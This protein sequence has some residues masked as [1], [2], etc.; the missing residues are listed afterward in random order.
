[1]AIADTISSMYD[2]V[3]DI[4]DTLELGGD[5]TQNKNIVNINTEIKR[6]YKDFLA[7]GTDTLWNN[8]EKVEGEGETLSLNNTMEGK[9]KVDLKGNTYQESTTGKNLFDIGT[10]AN[11]YT[12][13]NYISSI[14][15]NSITMVGAGGLSSRGIRLQN[16]ATNKTYTIGFDT[17][18]TTNR[19]L[20]RIR[21]S[22]DTGWLTN[23]DITFDGWNY[24]GTYGAWYKDFTKSGNRAT[25]TTTIP[26]GLYWQFGIVNAYN[27]TETFSNIQIEL[28]NQ[29]TN[30]EPYTGGQPSPSPSYP[31]DIQVVSGDNSINVSGENKFDKDNPNVIEGYIAKSNATIYLSNNQIIIYVPCQ[32]NTTYYVKR[33]LVSTPTNNVFRIGTTSTIPTSGSVLSQF[34][35]PDNEETATDYTFTTNANA[36]YIV[37]YCYVR[38][39]L[40]LIK[41]G[42]YIGECTTSPIS[43][44]NIEL[45]KIGTYQ[46]SIVKDNGKWYLNKQIGKAVLDGS[47]NWDIFFNTNG[48]FYYYNSIS[49]LANQ[50]SVNCLSNYFKATYRAYIR[51]NLDDANNV[52]A[53]N[54]TE[55]VI[56]N[57]N[58]SSASDFKTWLSTH[59]T[60]LYYVLAT[61]TYEEITGELLSQLE[62]LA[63]SYEG[64][65]NISQVND[66]M[67]FVLD[68]TALKDM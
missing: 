40:D 68:I 63:Y 3:G 65:T 4:Y 61:P 20:I 62:A 59:N 14:S 22:S 41:N 27:E 56:A 52:C 8:W 34:Y 19:G 24:N 49:G 26:N 67:P 30:W 57:K 39:S 5:T 6:E 28:N 17:N 55:F 64:T 2:H 43:L 32:P 7:N 45:C 53:V 18:V 48:I 10:S 51:N 47:E 1:M 50:G 13:T 15:N 23:S 60:T 44:G 35:V 37:W 9:M 31:Q 11:D 25:V 42:V 21:N 29:A 12:P 46:D 33:E 36:Q 38:E 16:F 58:I 54:G 66:D